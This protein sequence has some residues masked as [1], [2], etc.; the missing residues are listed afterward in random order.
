LPPGDPGGPLVAGNGGRDRLQLAGGEV[1]D[2]AGNVSEWTRD[3]WNR[4]YEPC[5]LGKPLLANPECSTPSPIDG[6]ARTIKG[7]PWNVYIPPA[8]FR[9]GRS[10]DVTTRSQTGFRCVRHAG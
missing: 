2:L 7:G 6:D 10:P 4:I 3:T 9:I 1:L 8:S 5:W